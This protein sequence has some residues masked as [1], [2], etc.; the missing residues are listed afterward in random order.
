METPYV[1]YVYVPRNPDGTLARTPNEELTVAAHPL[2]PSERADH[3]A[4]MDS[5]DLAGLTP[6]GR[7]RI[8]DALAYAYRATRTPR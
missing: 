7:R 3:Q 5:P 2:T 4:D 1:P 8:A 6:A